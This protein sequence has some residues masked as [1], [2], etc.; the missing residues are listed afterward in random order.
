MSHKILYLIRCSSVCNYIK[1]KEL[2]VSKYDACIENSVQEKIFGFSW[3]LDIV[4]DQWDVLVLD[5]YKAVMPI[6]WRKKIGVPV[7]SIWY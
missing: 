2:N 7:P 3:Y 4:A 5:D 6:P 1:R